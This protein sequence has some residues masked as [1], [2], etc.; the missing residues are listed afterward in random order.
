MP[1]FLYETISHIVHL[2]FQKRQ[3]FCSLGPCLP[4]LCRPQMLLN[5]DIIY[6]DKLIKPLISIGN[7]VKDYPA[8]HM[9]VPNLG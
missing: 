8:D 3:V 2:P 9:K 4:D 7:G 6:V 1:S 5:I